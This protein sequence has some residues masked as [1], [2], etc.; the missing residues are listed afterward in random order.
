[1]ENSTGEWVSHTVYSAGS[2]TTSTSTTTIDGHNTLVYQVSSSTDDAS[3]DGSSVNLNDNNPL[4]PGDSTQWEGWRFV[5]VQIPQGANI[6]SATLEFR[7]PGHWTNKAWRI[8]AEDVDNSQT[9]TSS[10]N[11]ISSRTRTTNSV[12]QS[13]NSN[14]GSGWWTLPG[15]YSSVIQEVID[16]PGWSSGNALTLI[17]RGNG[18]EY[19]RM[20]IYTYNQ[21]PSYGARLT[22][23]Y[24]GSPPP[25]SGIT[26]TTQSTT[27][28]TSMITTTTLSGSTTT[29]TIYSPPQGST[30]WTQFGHDPQR[31]TWTSEEIL[32]PWRII[33]MWNAAG[34]D[35]KKQSDH[36]PDPGL[37]QPI[38]GE[39]RVYTVA[40]NKVV[41]LDK[42]NGNVI[43]S[44]SSIGNLKGGPAYSNGYIYVP[45]ENGRMYKLDA[46]SGSTVDSFSGSG[47]FESP[48]LLV[49]DRIYAVS[50]NGILYSINKDTMNKIWEY[51][52]NSPGATCPSYSDSHRKIVF[53]TQDLNVHAVNEDGSLSWKTKPTNR[54]YVSGEVEFNNGWPVIADEHG[55]VFMR[56]RLPWDILMLGPGER[57]QFPHNNQDIK[58]FLTSHPEQQTLYALNLN[59]GTKAFIPAVGPGGQECR[60]PDNSLTIG[61]GPLPVIAKLDGEEVAYTYWRNGQRCQILGWCDYRWDSTLGEMVLDSNTVPG[62]SAGDIRFLVYNGGYQT[63]ELGTLSGSG[64]SFYYGHWQANMAERVID[65]SHNVGD[66][67]ENP[68][69]TENMPYIVWST[70]DCDGNCNPNLYPGGTGYSAC[71]S[72]CDSNRETHYCSQL[73]VYGDQRGYPAGFYEYL[74]DRYERSG[75][76]FDYPFTIVSDGLVLVKLV[77]GG[78]MAFEHGIH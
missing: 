25:G 78:I 44:K 16:R 9:F 69:K 36:L 35:D 71:H 66:T 21:G 20:Q 54:N 76:C 55:I 73:F 62:Y 28:T 49:G 6:Q 59:D 12:S 52:G 24:G 64:K 75:E 67:V 19:G 43:W 41:A 57:G 63:D 1:M 7:T 2:S 60:L 68:I 77:D 37:V 8:Y 33:W 46:S 5:N 74:N 31:T 48:V 45:S 34:P 4:W 50:S 29:S 26:T 47:E 15:D 38:T 10:S 14:I 61:L 39:G 22:I 3:Q 13:D 27:T 11:D 30:E 40:G 58:S 23:S 70:C 42:N 51:N 18:G 72:H 17:S 32:S 56:L 65:R 53:A